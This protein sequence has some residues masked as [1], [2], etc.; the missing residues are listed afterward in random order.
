M[1]EDEKERKHI[2]FKNLYDKIDCLILKIHTT[3]TT[4]QQNY[5]FYMQVP[6]T[7]SKIQAS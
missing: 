3:I 7:Q 2:N 4:D 1:A 5:G 6:L